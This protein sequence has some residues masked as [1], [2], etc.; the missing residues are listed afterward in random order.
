MPHIEKSRWLISPKFITFDGILWSLIESRE[1]G[2]K[3]LKEQEEQ[4]L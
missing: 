3:K 4:E 1:Y 2:G